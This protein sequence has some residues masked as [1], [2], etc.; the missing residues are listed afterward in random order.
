[1]ADYRDILKR[2]REREEAEGRDLSPSATRPHSISDFQIERAQA[3]IRE[4]ESLSASEL[5]RWENKRANQKR[6]EGARSLLSRAKIAPEEPLGPVAPPLPEAQ[7]PAGPVGT[8]MI[9]RQIPIDPER[10]YFLPAERG[11]P[12]DT[13]ENSD[14]WSP[15]GK[16]AYSDYL[17]TL[18]FNK[19]NR[20]R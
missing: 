16:N 18:F 11:R 8:P 2:I 13:T 4:Y 17:Q 19:Y 15:D 10:H 3:V 6:L 5:Q 14:G 9:T 7:Q 20:Q 1:M 12:V